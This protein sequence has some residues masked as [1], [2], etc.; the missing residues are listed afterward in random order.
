MGWNQGNAIYYMHK[1]GQIIFLNTNTTTK[2]SQSIILLRG[3]CK[4]LVCLFFPHYRF[5]FS[6]YIYSLIQSEEEGPASQTGKKKKKNTTNAFLKAAIK[7]KKRKS[8]T[9]E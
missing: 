7:K 2:T 9:G 6:N 1:K 3:D 5:V 8:N 4:N